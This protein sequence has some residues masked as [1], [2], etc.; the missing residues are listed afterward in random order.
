[1]EDLIQALQD[2]AI[3]LAPFSTSIIKPFTQNAQNVIACKDENDYIKL[4]NTLL[5]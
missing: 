3:T 2:C 5:I 4:G 1:M